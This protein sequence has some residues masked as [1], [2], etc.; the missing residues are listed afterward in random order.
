MVKRPESW[1]PYKMVDTRLP[2]IIDRTESGRVNQ[3]RIGI[4]TLS[5]IELRNKLAL[6]LANFTIECS[7]DNL[8]FKTAGY[9]H[10]VGMCQYGAD[11]MAKE[12]KDY[13]Q[14]LLYYYTGISLKWL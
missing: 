4:R 11:G 1:Q 3:A 12:G 6:R 5:G 14:I 7:K 13:R 2:Q 10:G 8:I 9:G